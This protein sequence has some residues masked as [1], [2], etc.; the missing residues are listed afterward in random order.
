MKALKVG[1]SD[2]AE[3]MHNCTTDDDVGNTTAP[4][5]DD[6]DVKIDEIFSCDLGTG[7]WSHTEKRY[8]Q[9]K[10]LVTFV[11]ENMQTITHIDNTNRRT[12]STFSLNAFSI[13][14]WVTIFGLAIVFILLKIGDRN[15]VPNYSSQRNHST[16]DQQSLLLRTEEKIRR[17]PVAF[18]SVGEFFI[19]F[20]FINGSEATFL[21]DHVHFY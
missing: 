15:F 4:D 18:T 7:G 21:L 20:I 19:L 2:F 8:D 13:R 5:D 17:F 9:V 11:H 10:F 1:F 6:D 16:S 12:S 3:R 14:V